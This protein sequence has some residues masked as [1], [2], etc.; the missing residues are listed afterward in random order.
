M[1]I[2]EKT[3]KTEKS[4]KSVLGRGAGRK[5][6][7]RKDETTRSVV[8]ESEALRP[9]E[10]REGSPEK[11]RTVLVTGSNGMAGVGQARAVPPPLPVPIASFKI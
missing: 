10:E 4:R 6:P 3:A 11:V 9:I 8:G 5:H 1:V 7:V 2:R